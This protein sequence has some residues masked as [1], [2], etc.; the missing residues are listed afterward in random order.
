MCLCTRM[1][2]TFFPACQVLN[3]INSAPPS[4]LRCLA[5]NEGVAVALVAPKGHWAIHCFRGAPDKC[6][7]LLFTALTN[8]LCR[9]WCRCRC[10]SQKVVITKANLAT[11]STIKLCCS[12][13]AAGAPRTES[14]DH[15]GK[16]CRQICHHSHPDVGEHDQQVCLPQTGVEG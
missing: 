10:L 14:D 11:A 8:R 16:P 5:K 6:M 13:V 12:G 9:S 2:H 7:C 1:H 15:Q 4:S 3:G